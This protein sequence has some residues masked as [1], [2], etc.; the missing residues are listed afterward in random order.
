M[1][2]YQINVQGAP[3]H[4]QKQWSRK[5]T[6]MFGR[7]KEEEAKLL[8]AQARLRQQQRRQAVLQSLRNQE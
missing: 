8:A 5:L 7:Y 1:P 3:A 4:L 2:K 6:E